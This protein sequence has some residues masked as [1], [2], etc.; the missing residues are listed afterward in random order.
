MTAGEV[1]AA[2]TAARGTLIAIVPDVPIELPGL[3]PFPLSSSHAVAGRTHRPRGLRLPRS[4]DP[5]IVVGDEGITFQAGVIQSTVPFARCVAALRFPDGSRSLASDDGFFVMV[6]P[7]L[8]KRGNEIVAAID[9][10]VPDELVVRMEPAL[11]ERAEAVEQTADE[12]LKRRWAVS[13]E[14]QL[15][16]ERL[17]PGEEIV[18]LAEAGKGMRAGLLA[19]TD[20]RVIFHARIWGDTW[21][22]FP[23][24]AIESVDGKEGLMDSTVT[25]VS[26]GEKTSFSSVT[27]KER[28]TEIAR[29]IEARLG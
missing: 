2:I 12:K 1:A 9:A 15:L 17:E 13:E 24:D 22:E 29:E 5:Q 25:I 3:T 8:W 7:T 21:L 18:T 20:R 19:V 6:D 23:Y 4:S 26:R 11:T 10:R 14:L 28:A 16:P 27:P